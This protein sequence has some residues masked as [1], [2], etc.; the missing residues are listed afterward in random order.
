[1]VCL[2]H[3]AS[4]KLSDKCQFWVMCVLCFCVCVRFRSK[5]VR[6]WMRAWP[7]PWNTSVCPTTGLHTHTHR[8][9]TKHTPSRQQTHIHTVMQT[10]PTQRH[11]NKPG[12]TCPPLWTAA[13]VSWRA[14]IVNVTVNHRSPASCAL[15]AWLHDTVSAEVTVVTTLGSAFETSE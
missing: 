11:T 2:L 7:W 6:G 3:T 10:D 4:R 15:C 13:V 8:W 14:F 9:I 5:S 12:W 1:M